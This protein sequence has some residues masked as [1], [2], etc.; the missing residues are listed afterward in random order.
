MDSQKVSPESHFGF[1][2]R[3]LCPQTRT[4]AQIQDFFLFQNKIC[5]KFTQL[6]NIYLFKKKNSTHS[7]NK[8]NQII[9]NYRKT[10]TVDPNSP[11]SKTQPTTTRHQNPNSPFSTTTPPTELPFPAGAS[12]TKIPSF[13][14]KTSFTR[15][16]QDANPFSPAFSFLTGLKHPSLRS[17]KVIFF[18]FIAAF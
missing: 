18:P 8:F 17:M 15:L 3:I 12:N 2:L 14:V 16:P 5:F 9:K 7:P 4:G 13:A 11:L 6:K 1:S 10:K